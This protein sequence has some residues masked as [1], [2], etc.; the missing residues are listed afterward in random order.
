MKHG[1]HIA[2]DNT[3]TAQTLNPSMMY[4]MFPQCMP[5]MHAQSSVQPLPRVATQ[6]VPG[7]NLSRPVKYQLLEERILA[8][9]GFSALGLNAR[10]LCLVSNVVLPQ[11]FKVP[12]V[13]KY[14]GLSCPLNH[15]TMY[16]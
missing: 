12:D 5:Q 7:T 2:Q 9:E 3:P 4:M 8:I 14:N 15:I 11:K 10:E 13:P 1:G 6:R 16:C